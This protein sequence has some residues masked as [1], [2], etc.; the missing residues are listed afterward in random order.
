MKDESKD[1]LAV[2]GAP[3][4]MLEAQE[5]AEESG[6]FEVLEENWDAV[7]I[8]SKLTSQWNCVAGASIV[9]LGLNYQSVD[10]LFRTYQVKK[11]SK[12]MDELQIMESAAK[13]ILNKK[14]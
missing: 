13:Q 5:D 14:E 1:D 9:Y 11:R 7:L 8:F 4:E 2:F 6:D 10:F 12:V 3:A